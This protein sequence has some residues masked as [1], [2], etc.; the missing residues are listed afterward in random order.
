M[1]QRMDYTMLI[2]NFHKNGKAQFGLNLL[3]RSLEKWTSF[4]KHINK[5]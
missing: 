5:K 4:A 2:W 3:D 1:S